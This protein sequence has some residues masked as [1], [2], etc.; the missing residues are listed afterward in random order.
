MSRH[1]PDSCSVCDG[2]CLYT[3]FARRDIVLTSVHNESNSQ[4]NEFDGPNQFSQQ[5]PFVSPNHYIPQILN[6]PRHPHANR[7]DQYPYI[8]GPDQPPQITEINNI[9]ND[10]RPVQH[11]QIINGYVQQQVINSRKLLF[12]FPFSIFNCSEEFLS[13][14]MENIYEFDKEVER[15]RSKMS[16]VAIL[17][18][19]KNITKVRN[20]QFEFEFN[21]TIQT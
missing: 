13:I 6:G 5:P 12:P 9:N 10:F 18:F 8:N 16:S 17:K 2:Y 3:R 21:K 14:I 20:N 1:Y 7:P 4:I 15:L 19:G 11:S